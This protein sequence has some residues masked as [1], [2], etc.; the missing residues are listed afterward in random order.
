MREEQGPGVGAVAVGLSVCASASTSATGDCNRVTAELSPVPLRAGSCLSSPYSGALACSTYSG[1]SPV[2]SLQRALACPP[3]TA[4]LSP[5]LSL[6]R[7]SPCSTYSRLSPVLSLQRGLACPD[8]T[9]PLLF[10]HV[11]CCGGCPLQGGMLKGISDLH[12]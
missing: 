12:P 1:L 6:Q 9:E 5:V 4:G 10:T 8:T 2:L 11:L 7:G 3:L